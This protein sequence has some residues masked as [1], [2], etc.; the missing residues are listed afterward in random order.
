MQ[1][2]LV[3]IYKLL[4]ISINKL[5]NSLVCRV[6]VVHQICT[7]H[8]N[9]LLLSP[10]PSPFPCRRAACLC[11]DLQ[12]M[13][14]TL[15]SKCLNLSSLAW[16][17]S[18]SSLFLFSPADMTP[19]EWCMYGITTLDGFLFCFFRAAFHSALFLSTVLQ[20]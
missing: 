16:P 5:I 19:H 1:A 4:I 11:S 10:S 14:V 18:S 3:N 2:V 17:C 13:C 7:E 6:S 20:K 8:S 9:L 15:E 12:V